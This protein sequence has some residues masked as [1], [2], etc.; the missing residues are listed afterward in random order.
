MLL[1]DFRSAPERISFVSRAYAASGVTQSAWD[2]LRAATELDLVEQSD[3]VD[4]VALSLDHENFDLDVETADVAVGR[5]PDFP[6]LYLQRGG[7]WP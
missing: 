3:S 7:L 6:C 5:L 2:A 1:S 4:L